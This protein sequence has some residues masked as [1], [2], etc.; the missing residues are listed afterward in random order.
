[1]SFNVIADCYAKPERHSHVYP[2]CLF[3]THR[4][5]L[6][7]QELGG[8]TGGHTLPPGSRIQQVRRTHRQPTPWEAQQDAAQQGPDVASGID[9]AVP[10][11]WAPAATLPLPPTSSPVTPTPH[12]RRVGEYQACAALKQYAVVVQKKSADHPVANAVFFRSDRLQLWWCE[13]RTRALL[14][15]LTFADSLGQV[16]SCTG[17]HLQWPPCSGPGSPASRA[18]FWRRSSSCSCSR[19]PATLRPADARA[20]PGQYGAW[21]RISKLGTRAWA[22][23]G[24]DNRRQLPHLQP[25]LTAAALA[26][27]C[28]DAVCQLLHRGMLEGGFTE[29]FLPQVPAAAW[30]LC[31]LLALAL[32]RQLPAPIV[33]H[34]C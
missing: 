13:H 23:A 27:R 34:S 19:R 16:R 20:V 15:A 26:A 3:W 4:W 25:S 7:Q 18:R 31:F 24:G 30:P 29:P 8:D 28:R 17:S 33:A 6:L 22:P 11:G 21:R 14:L 10:Q 2:R 32:L 1:M 5:P 9:V 12:A